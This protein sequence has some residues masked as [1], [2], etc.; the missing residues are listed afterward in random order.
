MQKVSGSTISRELKRNS[1]Q[2]GYRYQQANQKAVERRHNASCRPT[3]MTPPLIKIVEAKL[4]EAW[5]PE[6]ISGVL[7]SN[8][9]LISHESIYRDI[10]T[11]KTAGGGLYTH[12]FRSGDSIRGRSVE[13]P[14]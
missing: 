5:S 9:I 12:L 4:F 13:Q 11:D 7:R 3:K 8:H 14:A 6:Q 1:R 2:R 10:W